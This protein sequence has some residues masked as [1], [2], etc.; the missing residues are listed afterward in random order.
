MKDMGRRAERTYFNTEY[1]PSVREEELD[2]YY[3]GHYGEPSLSEIKKVMDAVIYDDIRRFRRVC[4]KYG[5]DPDRFIK[6][7]D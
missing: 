2:V 7:K 3:V 6:I 5:Y 4:K 1:M